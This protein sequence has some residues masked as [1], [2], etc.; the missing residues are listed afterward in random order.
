[1][2]IFSIIVSLKCKKNIYKKKH[3]SETFFCIKYLLYQ[4]SYN[5]HK[6]H[7]CI[8]NGRFYSEIKG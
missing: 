3:S 2:K 8:Q 4:I 6:L 5:I 1:M 7:L